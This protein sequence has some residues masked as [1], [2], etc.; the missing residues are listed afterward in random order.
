MP[1]L[2]VSQ[3]KILKLTNALIYEVQTEELEDL[4]ANM[5]QMENYI[6]VKGAQPVGP[7]IQYTNVTLDEQGQAQ[8][9]IKMIRQCSNF[10]HS[11]EQPYRMDSVL[12][13]KS[14]MYVRYTGPEEKLK[15]AYDKINLASFEEE[16]PLRGDS[17]T[18][19]VDKKEED[20]M[21]ADVFMP[22]ADGA[23]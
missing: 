18:I 12:R 10:L 2:Q 20:C 5:E 23:D 9:Q 3:D 17:Y 14:C 16:I 19:F 4:N 15:F 13:V 22:K 7:L 21:I 6:R 11:V 8:L 1:K